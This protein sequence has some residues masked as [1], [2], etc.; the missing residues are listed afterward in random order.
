MIPAARSSPVDLT[1]LPLTPRDWR[2]T[3][4]RLFTHLA[5]YRLRILLGFAALIAAKAA[6]VATPLLLKT[7]IDTLAYRTPS[8]APSLHPLP[9]GALALVV[10]YGSARA[11]V[12]LFTELREILFARVVQSLSRQLS[13]DV[14]HHLL[15]LSLRFHLERQTGGLS[16]DIERGTRAV[17]TFINLTI[18]SI[19]PT[20][21][22]LLMVLALLFTLYR[23]LYGLIVA[24]TL[25]FYILYTVLITNW[26]THLRRHLNRLDA[27][28]HTRAIDA[29]LNYETV[30]YFN[31]ETYEQQR[32]DQ[33]LARWQQ[34]AIKNQYS[35]SLLN[36]GQAFII[37]AGVTLMLFL[38]V[39]EIEQGRLTVGDLVLMNGVMLQ[40]YM[41]LN[42]LG[43][44]Y[45]E[46]RQSLVDLERLFA[47]LAIKPEIRDPIT[48]KPL[49][50]PP[51]AI[52]F[53]RVR[54]AYDPRRPILD[55]FT[56]TIP[57]GKTVAVVGPSG[58][59]K[60]TLVRLLFRF[61]DVT[62]GAIRI[63]GIDIRELSQL[64][65]RRAIGIVP[66]DTVLFNDTLEYNIRYGRPEVTDAEL[67]AAIRAARLDQLI[68][69]LPDG[70]NTLVGERGLK[71]SGGEKQRVAIAR[72]FLK[73]PPILILDEA[74]SALDTATERDIQSELAAARAG[75][76][77]LMIAHRLSTVRDA[78]EIVVLDH[79]QIIERGTHETLLARGGRYAELWA[80][81][82][83][84]SSSPPPT[85]P[86]SFS[87]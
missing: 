74:T 53:D 59:G 11:M 78:D 37:A 4:L 45:R 54:F 2:N 62:G 19:L 22:E 43:V 68:A 29:L 48:P 5:P 67:W 61:Y 84:N 66:Q 87:P 75:R 60:S 79:G 3:L 42:F 36:V 20:L 44:V 31:N 40:L 65:L 12:S 13:L 7:L 21:I 34:I 52:E 56:L 18:F 39:H 27:Q 49:P 51:L 38:A 72:V 30:K 58:A 10:A 64:Q 76:T 81:Q 33:D 6:L 70:L 28:T 8:P 80:K 26:R 24:V 9:L 15:H 77:T 63:G 35:L 14:F 41:P 46:I 1:D 16:R 85:P 73:N 17:G 23:P 83:E 57:A 71:L 69:R 32:Y 82:S 47:L 50:S 86:L 55:D 25:F